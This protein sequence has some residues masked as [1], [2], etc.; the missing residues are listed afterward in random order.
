MEPNTHHSQRFFFI[1]LCVIP[2]LFTLLAC[3]QPAPQISPEKEKPVLQPEDIKQPEPAEKK[4]DPFSK[5][6]VIQALSAEAEKY[7]LKNNY[8][9][10]LSIYNQIL[11]KISEDRKP[12]IIKTIIT[13]LSKTPAKDIE[14]WNH[15]KDIHIPKPL[16]LYYLGLNYALENNSEKS[17]KALELYLSLYP[18]HVYN[19]DALSLLNELKQSLF[20]K[21]TIGCLLPLTGRYSVFGQ[22]ALSGIQLAVQKLSETYSKEFK[23]IVFDTQADPEKTTEGVKSLY[24]RNVAAIIGPLLVEGESGKEAEKLRIPLIALTQKAD[25]ALQGEYLFSNFITPEMQV[26]ALS[27]Y[28]FSKLGVKK[29]AILY[30]KERYGIK[31]MELFHEA[32]KEYAGE[33]VGMEPYDGK[34]TDLSL[35]VKRIMQQHPLNPGYTRFSQTNTKESADQEDTSGDET[36]ENDYEAEALKKNKAREAIE[37]GRKRI[38]FQALFIPDSPSRLSLILPLLAY[39]EA[40]GIYLLGTNLWHDDTFLKAMKGSTHKVIFP[41]GFFESSQNIHAQDFSRDFEAVFNRKPQFLEAIAYDTASMIFLTAMDD[42]I[43]SREDLKKALNGRQIYEGATGPTRFD[44]NGISHRPLILM[45]VKNGE[46]IE[47]TQ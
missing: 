25:F 3:A 22:R 32:A 1:F 7:L 41:D 19:N 38:E 42:S 44:E 43:T 17:I 30:P 39:N 16:I 33:I 6:S 20:S 31:Y 15:G 8:Q 29:M 46:F 9:D 13:V 40:R 28:I 26:Q 10:A 37:A 24:E 27:N 11:S 45:T 23:T 12:E 36:A 35:P 18:G 4:E 5:P 34:K 47:I 21:D 14:Q 2:V